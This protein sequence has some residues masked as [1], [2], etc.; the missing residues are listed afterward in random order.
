[1]KKYVGMLFIFAAVAIL[2]VKS[3][4]VVDAEVFGGYIVKGEVEGGD[5]N[6]ATDVKGPGYGFRGHFNNK[7]VLFNV[8]LGGYWQKF[9]ADYSESNND[10]EN[11]VTSY[12]F[13]AYIKLDIPLM[14]FKPYVRG[15]LAIKDKYDVEM[16]NSFGTFSGSSSEKFNS[17]YYGIGVAFTVLPLPALDVQVYGEYVYSHYKGSSDMKGHSL[18]FGALASL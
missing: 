13:D 18:N 5:A 2:P 4:A 11:T 16:S 15:G 9:N 14:P 7:I 3:F 6:G 17:S 10:F 8:G 12:G 1:M